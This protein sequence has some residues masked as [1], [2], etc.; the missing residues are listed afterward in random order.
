MGGAGGWPYHPGSVHGGGVGAGGAARETPA[1]APQLQ[2]QLVSP[3]T[4]ARTEVEEGSLAA[5]LL[6]AA[7]AAPR[8]HAYALAGFSPQPQAPQRSASVQRTV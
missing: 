8:Q 7:R 1:A 3:P 4:P 5:A 2:P 6:D